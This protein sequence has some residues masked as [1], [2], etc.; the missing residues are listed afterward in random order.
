MVLRPSATKCFLQHEK[1]YFSSNFIN[2][3]CF[4]HK[5]KFIDGIIAF[6][7]IIAN[8]FTTDICIME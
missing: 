2:E 6:Y 4:K 5:K 8:L 3:T 1:C 7:N